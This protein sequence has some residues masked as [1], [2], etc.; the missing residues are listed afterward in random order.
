[1][2]GEEGESSSANFYI[3]RKH[4]TATQSGD[5]TAYKNIQDEDF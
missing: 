2:Y 3:L 5:I 1:M 4:K